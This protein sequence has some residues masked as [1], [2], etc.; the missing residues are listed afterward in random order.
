MDKTV[1]I[2]TYLKDYFLNIIFKQKFLVKKDRGIKTVTFQK[3]V[4]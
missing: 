1:S 2:L 4:L 3:V